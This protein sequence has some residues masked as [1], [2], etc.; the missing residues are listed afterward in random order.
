M[1]IHMCSVSFFSPYWLLSLPDDLWCE[2]GRLTGE[3]PP[4]AVEDHPG[5]VD[6]YLRGGKSR[7]TTRPF[8]SA[9]LAACRS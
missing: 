8:A 3:P 7:A 4:R 6:S 1:S 9:S 5:G 2:F